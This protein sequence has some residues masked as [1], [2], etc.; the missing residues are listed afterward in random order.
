ME[1]TGFTSKA[2]Q[3]SQTIIDRAVH[4]DTEE[5]CN[6]LFSGIGDSQSSDHRIA[7]GIIFHTL[8]NLGNEELVDQAEDDLEN[9]VS[10]LSRGYYGSLLTLKG[11]IA[12]ENGDLVRATTLVQEGSEIIDEAV[13]AD[14]ENITLRFLRLE[15]GIGVSQGSPFDRYE[16]IAE[17]AEFLL[18]HRELQS[19]ENRARVLYLAGEVA[20]GMNDVYTCLD[21]LE[22][23]LRAAPESRWAQKADMLLWQL[24]E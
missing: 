23:A 6:N 14:P 17:D 11:G 1:S 18:E 21:Y 15:N 8:I 5:S 24:E 7:R 10:P 20:L 13:A 12:S 9:A 3:V 16:A 4:S 22:G 2:D 19:G